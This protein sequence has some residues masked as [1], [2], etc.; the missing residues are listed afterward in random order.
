MKYTS[1]RNPSF[2]A[3]VGLS[4]GLGRVR[5]RLQGLCGSLDWPSTVNWQ[6]SYQTSCSKRD[7]RAWE[8]GYGSLQ[9]WLGMLERSCLTYHGDA[10]QPHEDLST[11][12][13]VPSSPIPSSEELWPEGLNEGFGHLVVV[14]VFFCGSRSNREAIVSLWIYHSIDGWDNPL[15]LRLWSHILMWCVYVNAEAKLTRW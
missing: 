13:S 9:T 4:L 15:V 2:L 11:L 10:K 5:R 12:V 1:Y 7:G 3:L 14:F 6:T 8:A